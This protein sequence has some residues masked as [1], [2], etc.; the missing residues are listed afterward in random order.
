MSIAEALARK[1]MAQAVSQSTRHQRKPGKSVKARA[2]RK[3]GRH[4]LQ[5]ANAMAA[6]EKALRAIPTASEVE[7]CREIGLVAAAYPTIW[8]LVRAKRKDLLKLPGLGERR[9]EK[10]GKY[11]ARQ[12]DVEVDW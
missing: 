9:L 11:L 6:M 4:W 3:T 10:I 8:D 12:R 7:R 5:T 2:P 1:Q